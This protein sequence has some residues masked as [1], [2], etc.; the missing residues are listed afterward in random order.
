MTIAQRYEATWRTRKGSNR[1]WNIGYVRSPRWEN[2]NS[3]GETLGDLSRIIREAPEPK[4]CLMKRLFDYMTAENQTIDGGYLDHLTEAFERE[5]AVSSSAAMKNAIVRVLK[6]NTYHERNADPQHCYDHAPDAKVAKGPP[7]RVAFILQKNCA[8]CHGTIYGGDANLDLGAWIT[9]P[10]GKNRT[11]PHLDDDMQQRPAQDTITRM[12]ERLVVDRSEE[13]HAQEQDH[14]EPGAPGALPVGAAGAVAHR[15]GGRAMKP[16]AAALV[17]GVALCAMAAD[18]AA[19]TSRF[20]GWATISK[21]LSTRIAPKGETLELD[22]FLPADD[23][24]DLL[25]SWST[26][27]SEHAFQNGLP[28]SVSIAIWHATPVE[29]RQE[30][31]RV[32][33]PAAVRVPCQ[34]RRRLLQKLCTWPAA[35]AKTDALLM[36]YWLSIM[37]YNAPEA[38]YVAWRDYFLASYQGP[39]GR[40][41]RRRHDA[42]DHHEP[43][44]PA[45]QVSRRSR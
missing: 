25:G 45:A 2:Q 43:L 6:S 33:P 22:R 42:G 11:F 15:Q 14:V 20:K 24:E 35:G 26:F 31:R 44:L 40:R 13:A 5:A 8:Q 29:L 9:A 12:M 4:R 36:D 27:G 34:V 30:H 21:E 10:D 28:N 19:Q 18:G 37:G 3:Y 17:A 38:E 7:C 16:L 39:A 23:M 1:K 32:L 41:D